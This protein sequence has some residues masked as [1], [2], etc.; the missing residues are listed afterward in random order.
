MADLVEGEGG[1]RQGRCE[2]AGVFRREDRQD[3]KPTWLTGRRVQRDHRVVCSFDGDPVTRILH[4]LNARGQSI[5][6]AYTLP[7]TATNLEP[8]HIQNQHAIILLIE[9]P[10]RREMPIPRLSQ[11]LPRIRQRHQTTVHPLRPRR[12]PHR[13]P[14][15]RN[16]LGPL[17]GR[18][19]HRRRPDRRRQPVAPRQAR[20]LGKGEADLGDV[21]ERA[22]AVEHCFG[23]ITPRS[24]PH[25]LGVDLEGIEDRGKGAE[26]AIGWL[27]L[28]ENLQ[29]E[30]TVGE[31]LRKDG[32]AGGPEWAW[33]TPPTAGCLHATRG[34]SRTPCCLLV[35]HARTAAFL[36]LK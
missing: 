4:S 5:A 19:I 10:N 2:T 3:R 33:R 6:N 14:E 30:G 11:T 26:G 13:R 32:G 12:P 1:L 31:R 22:A 20:K 18:L 34:G 24:F 35:K 25:A 16:P 9:P 7:P 17:L 27:V 29:K 28:S 21:V 8:R 15:V 23:I 36:R